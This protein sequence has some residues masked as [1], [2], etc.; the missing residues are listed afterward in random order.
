MP[1]DI[2]A[3][4][5]AYDPSPAELY[6]QDAEAKTTVG[7]SLF[8][9]NT[10]QLSTWA[11][12]STFGGSA[13]FSYD[14]LRSF[15]MPTQLDLF[16][17][18]GLV[19]FYHIIDT[20]NKP[21][22]DFAVIPPESGTGPSTT[23]SVPV[24]GLGIG[25]DLGN[26]S[27]L[28]A[29]YGSFPT[30]GCTTWVS[31]PSNGTVY[32]TPGATQAVRSTKLV[33]GEGRDASGRVGGFPELFCVDSSTKACM[34]QYQ[35][36]SKRFDGGESIRFTSNLGATA[37]G[38]GA[39]SGCRFTPSWSLTKRNYAYS[40]TVVEA[41]EMRDIGYT[42]LQLNGNF[43]FTA[44][45]VVNYNGYKFKVIAGGGISTRAALFG[46]WEFDQKKVY[47]VKMIARD[48]YDGTNKIQKSYDNVLYPTD[49]VTKAD[50][51]KNFGENASLYKSNPILSSMFNTSRASF[52]KSSEPIAGKEQ[53]VEHL[54]KDIETEGGNVDLRTTPSSAANPSLAA[55]GIDTASLNNLGSSKVQVTLE[56]GDPL[57]TGEKLFFNKDENLQTLNNTVGAKNQT[58]KKLFLDTQNMAENLNTDINSRSSQSY[59]N[60]VTGKKTKIYGPVNRFDLVPKY[61]HPE[62][63]TL[64]KYTPDDRENRTFNFTLTVDL[65]DQTCGP[66]SQTTT[67]TPG[68]PTGEVDEEGEPILGE[69]TTTTTTC[70]SATSPTDISIPVVK[71]IL[72]NLTPEANIW[73]QICKDYGGS[74]QNVVYQDLAGQNTGT[75]DPSN[76]K[77]GDSYYNTNTSKLRIYF[78][79]QWK[80]KEDTNLTN[81]VIKPDAL[82]YLDQPDFTEQKKL[83]NDNLTGNNKSYKDLT[84]GN[85]E[86]T[87]NL[88]KD[89]NNE[90]KKTNDA[91]R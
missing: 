63:T 12:P 67:T 7:K 82:E 45:Q 13:S 51:D 59:T 68:E 19:Y 40:A 83:L 24:C 42:M 39:G 77:E 53:K 17:S 3:E 9:M 37:E 23:V 5:G 27:S 43:R 78:N 85:L 35:S 76:A 16:L 20:S 46:R 49:K 54:I 60:N 88:F 4:K 75:S 32:G 65:W 1:I 56:K 81:P 31:T 61:K 14:Q 33:P 10:S 84:S 29:D 28:N 11:S 70:S 21:F 73:K 71:V 25:P 30:G 72:N 50:F 47:W 64:Q 57:P 6:N 2:T 8:R 36:G 66:C 22:V 74:L 52:P 15:L 86:K 80:N 26:V 69:G 62:Y 34:V 55:A 58:P 89:L 90:R 87:E 44:D 79:G 48:D 91:N 41:Y 38:T 18:E